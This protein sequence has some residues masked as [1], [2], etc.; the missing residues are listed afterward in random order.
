MLSGFRGYS[1]SNDD[2]VK[3]VNETLLG[4]RVVKYGIILFELL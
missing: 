3:V 4:V 1:V 2:R